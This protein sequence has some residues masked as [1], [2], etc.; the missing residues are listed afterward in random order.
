L[1]CGAGNRWWRDLV[2]NK[3]VTQNGGGEKYPTYNKMEESNWTGHILHRSC[4]IKNVTEG[5]VEGRIEVTERRV[6]RCKELLDDLKKRRRYFKLKKEA[7][8]RIP[9]RPRFAVVCGPVVRH[10]NE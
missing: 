1:K 2:I 6:R 8:D 5:N 10:R 9:C 7:L 4:L 3:D